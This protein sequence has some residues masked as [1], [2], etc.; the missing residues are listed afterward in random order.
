MDK[1]ER[2]RTRFLLHVS[3]KLAAVLRIP[4]QPFYDWV[5]VR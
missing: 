5:G 1:S 2:L 4:Y 3:R